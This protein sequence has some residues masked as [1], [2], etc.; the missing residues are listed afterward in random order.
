[1]FSAD[2]VEAVEQTSQNLFSAF[3]LLVA[4]GMSRSFMLIWQP[5][6]GSTLIGRCKTLWLFCSLLFC[7]SAHDRLFQLQFNA[8]ALHLVSEETTVN[9]SWFGF[10]LPFRTRYSDP[11]SSEPQQNRPHTDQCCHSETSQT[12]CREDLCDDQLYSGMLS[13][14]CPSVLSLTSRRQFSHRRCLQAKRF[15]S[16]RRSCGCLMNPGSR[17]TR[18]HTSSQCH[19]HRCETA[20]G[21]MMMS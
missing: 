13:P 7:C 18:P 8:A 14:S 19:L 15:I 3:Y 9:V 16:I 2:H 20:G 6:E 21:Q 17:D 11:G 5:H 12:C 1:M 10:Y 4:V